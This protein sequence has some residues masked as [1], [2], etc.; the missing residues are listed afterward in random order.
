M[1][2]NDRLLE[3]E[4]WL[5]LNRSGCF[6]PIS[7]RPSVPVIHRL[8]QSQGHPDFRLLNITCALIRSLT[9]SRTSS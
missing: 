8:F 1:R 9:C 2:I 7:Q 5:R 4:Q 3:T 6:Q